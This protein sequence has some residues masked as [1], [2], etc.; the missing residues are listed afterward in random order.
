MV[1]DGVHILVCAGVGTYKLRIVSWDKI[2]HSKY[3]VFKNK[4]KIKKL[5]YH[6]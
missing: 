1:L 3:R 2:S 5:N 4:N 6:H